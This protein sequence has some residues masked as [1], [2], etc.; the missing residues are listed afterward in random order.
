MTLEINKKYLY[1]EQYASSKNLSD[2]IALHEFGPEESFHVWVYG[3]WNI[4]QPV[5]ILDIGCGSGKFWEEN[6][7]KLPKGSHLTLSDFSAKM[8]NEAKKNVNADIF[9]VSDIDNLEFDDN[10]FDVVMAHHLLYHSSD[11]DK[12][13]RELKRVVKQNGMI[14]I[15]TNSERHM[16]NVYDIGKQIDK[17]FPTD[18][19][20]DSFVEE[21]ADKILA[22]HFSSIEKYVNK[23]LLKVTVSSAVIDY[24]KS[25]VTPRN[26]KLG[27]NFYNKY[28]EIIDNSIRD[29]GYF[30]IQ[31]CSPL[32]ICR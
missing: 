27:D 8:L 16:L 32:Y 12:S 17:N 29:N 5:S 18:R 1:T 10:S 2:R 15:T 30:A 21:K 26:I 20:I 9:V 7:S 3:K 13:L 11:K 24:V 14:S 25:G 28:L 23:D 19:I 4:T 31:K 22:N 6:L